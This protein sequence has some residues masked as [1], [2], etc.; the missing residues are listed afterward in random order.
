MVS[1][2]FLGYILF[3]C[4]FESRGICN[5]DLVGLKMGVELCE[6]I[7]LHVYL[8]LRNVSLTCSNEYIHSNIYS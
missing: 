3:W 5:W 7:D 4:L 2:V 6:V 1:P 8:H